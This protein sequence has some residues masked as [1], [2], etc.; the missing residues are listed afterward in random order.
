MKGI[1]DISAD[2]RKLY[3][4]SVALL[5]IL[6]LSLF[7]PVWSNM[8]VLAVIMAIAAIVVILAVKK[9]SILSKYKWQV[10]L[11]VSLCAVLYVML[12]YISGI[13]FGFVSISDRLTWSSLFYS[14]IPIAIIIIAI[15][16]I[17]AILLAQNDKTVSITSYVFCVL[18][19]VLIRTDLGRITDFN[20]F[21]D[22]F[23]MTLLPAMVWG[24]LYH[25]LSK[26]YGI[27]P[28]A[29]LRVIIVLY[30]YFIP[31]QPAMPDALK[32]FFRLIIPIIIFIFLKTLYDK[33]KGHS[34]RKSRVA[35]LLATSIGAVFMIS[36]VM[37]ISCQFRYGMVIIGSDS[38]TGELNKGDAVI[39]EDC[40]GE[41]IDV[42]QVIV[43]K[44]NNVKVV[45]R[46]IDIVTI[47]GETRYYTQGDTN[48]DPDH[49]YITDADM[50]G[51][52]RVKISYIGYP[53]VWLREIFK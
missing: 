21:M 27:Y 33:R 53:T 43:F 17:R 49:G 37:L 38:M 15:E 11:I 52:T 30:A 41:H 18:S 45:H 24:G 44:K 13:Y 50:I 5:C 40:D 51:I 26:S 28:N 19:D 10:L 25:Y 48:P 6:L 29:V 36:I 12:Y 1:K 8:Y 39:Y 20:G 32:A 31:V 3:I 23:G 16:I 7:L 22:I 47:D 34:T 46:V 42:G 2:K 14:I 4:I 9:R 35:S